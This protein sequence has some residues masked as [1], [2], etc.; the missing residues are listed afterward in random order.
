M[1]N[2]R[3]FP[4]KGG[5]WYVGSSSSYMLCWFIEM[6]WFY[7]FTMISKVD[8]F[9]ETWISQLVI[10]FFDFIL[11]FIFFHS[12]TRNQNVTWFHRYRQ[13]NND[14]CY[15][16]VSFSRWQIVRSN[17]KDNLIWIFLGTDFT[18][19]SRHLIVAPWNGLTKTSQF[20]NFPEIS[21]IY[22]L[23]DTVPCNEYVLFFW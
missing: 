1:K 12:N 21:I 16:F 20:S 15:I 13:I 18:W 7:T 3:Y 9:R 10:C 23:Y 2:M 8:T 19:S 11:M 4:T 6:L 22:V 14:L 17:V 5:R